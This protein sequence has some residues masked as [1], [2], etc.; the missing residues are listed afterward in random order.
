MKIYRLFG[1][2]KGYRRSRPARRLE[3]PNDVA[4]AAMVKDIAIAQPSFRPVRLVPI[5]RPY[6]FGPNIPFSLAG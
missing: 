2:K 1:K 6:E 4:A 5:V 3:A